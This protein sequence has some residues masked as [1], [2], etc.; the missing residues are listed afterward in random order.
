MRGCCFGEHNS[1][2]DSITDLLFVKEYFFVSLV[3]IKLEII[4]TQN[5]CARMYKKVYIMHVH[6]LVVL[7]S[8]QHRVRAA[9]NQ[10]TQ[11]HKTIALSR[12]CCRAEQLF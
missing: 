2:P 10:N 4:T 11:V 12:P 5:S 6:F 7:F 3:R 9:S 8:S 1:L